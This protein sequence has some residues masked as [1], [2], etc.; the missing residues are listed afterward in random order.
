[1]ETASPVAARRVLLVE[2]SADHAEVIAAT[3][4]RQGPFTQIERVET[5]DAFEKALA[6]HSWDIVVSDFHLP[7]FSAFDALDSLAKSKQR[8]PLI[9]VSGF[10]GEEAAAELMRAGAADFITKSNLQRL[11][12]AISRSLREARAMRERESALEALRESEERFRVLADATPVL[13]WQ[14]GLDKLCTYFNRSWLEFTG[15][16]LE[17]ELG[18]R[19]AEGIHPDDRERWLRIYTT[20]FDRRE[21]FELEYRLRRAD[22]EYGWIFDRA[23]PLFGSGGVFLG[24]LGGCVD[25]ARRKLDEAE[26]LR[27][28][29]QLRELS[30]HLDRAKEEERASIAREVHDEL[31][32]VLTAAKIEIATLARRLPTGG[33]DIESRIQSAEALL[34]Q[35]MEASRNISR[36]LRPAI[37]DYGIVAAVEWQARDFAKR[38]GIPC[39]FSASVDDIELNSEQATAVFRI[40]QEALT[41]IARHA[42]AR[43]V[44]VTLV[45]EPDG[46]L[47][48]R[49]TDDGCGIAPADADKP[50]S[51]GLRNMRERA[52]GLGGRIEVRPA[53]GQGTEVMLRV[54]LPD[55]DAKLDA[56]SR[57]LPFEA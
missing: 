4:E 23:V 16:T 7:S 37:L 3:L 6:N 50:G 17:Q 30:R 2:D 51:F 29:E 52:H 56:E 26:L 47:T 48:L 33:P 14:S 46:Y 40:L 25:I 28:H 22:G 44:Q 35:A 43:H 39:H 55:P 57:Q 5:R 1:V 32:V 13:I 18:N 36:K 42:R 53:A 27:S 12:G 21:P 9:V 10:V 34:D 54:P 19:W 24:Y 49:V 45:E 38:L 8:I 31:G 20:S 15:R 41:N 11:P